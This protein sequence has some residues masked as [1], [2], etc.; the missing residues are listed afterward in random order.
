M[1]IYNN[2]G[3]SKK[4]A[5]KK[6][7]TVTDGSGISHRQQLLILG[8]NLAG[9]EAALNGITLSKRLVYRAR[10]KNKMKEAKPIE[11]T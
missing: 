5:V 11:E 9:D 2:A 3:N 4:R 10:S 6:T 7:C 8:K 1:Q